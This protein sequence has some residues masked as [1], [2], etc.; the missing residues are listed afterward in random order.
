M[1]A[2]QM[3]IE[4]TIIGVDLLPIKP[5]HNVK[6]FQEDITT[7][8]CRD[9]IKRE[10]H[11]KHVG[12]SRGRSPSR[13]TWCFTMVLRMWEEAGARMPLTRFVL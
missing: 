4:S 8:H 5:I 9:V 6:T 1:A 10:L 11:G 13:R 2:K 7:L 3:P 12:Q